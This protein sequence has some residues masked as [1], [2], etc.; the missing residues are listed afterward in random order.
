MRYKC[1]S[2]LVD[3]AFACCLLTVLFVMTIVRHEV[4][5]CERN[6]L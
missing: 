4:F 2:I 5:R 6:D 3:P 1:G